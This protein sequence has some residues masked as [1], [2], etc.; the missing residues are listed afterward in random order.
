MYKEVLEFYHCFF[1]L[2]SEISTNKFYENLAEVQFMHEV[3][4]VELKNDLLLTEQKLQ[5]RPRLILIITSFL[6]LLIAE[7][8]F[9]RRYKITITN[10]KL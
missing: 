5:G 7:F 6:M 1:F 3:N 10:K 2:Q 8:I 9:W 4:C